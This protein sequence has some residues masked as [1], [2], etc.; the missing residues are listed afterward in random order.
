MNNQ[1]VK[2]NS[3]ELSQIARAQNVLVNLVPAAQKICIAAL[4]QKISDIAPINVV[5]QFSAI[6][7]GVYT[8]AGQQPEASTL[9]LYIDEFYTK[10]SETYPAITIDE[11][12][13]ALRNGVYGDYGKYYGLN[14]QT[15]L[16]FVKSYL[17]S[18]ERKEAL[19][20]FEGKKH[21]LSEVIL[22]DSEKEKSNEDF[23]NILYES[24]LNDKLL[25][26]FIPCYLFRFLWDRKLIVLSNDEKKIIKAKADSY[27][28]RLMS[29]NRT[30]SL[31]MRIPA[32]SLVPDNVDL[33]R[34]NIAKQFAI[35]EFFE[36]QRSLG[37]TTIF[38]DPLLLTEEN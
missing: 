20:L 6:I 24:F 25:S 2:S 13:A 19:K 9:A 35:Y 16:S 34:R 33:S 29:A 7:T 23:I 4:Q 26:D 32:V 37:K 10:L 12:R 8:I 31:L 38:S 27:H 36:N 17:F 14:P 22:T 18:D 5:D 3:G 30:A 1:I 28:I 11:V 21:L 15:F